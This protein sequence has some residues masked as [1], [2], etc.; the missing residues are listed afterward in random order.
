CWG[1]GGDGAVGNNSLLGSRIPVAVQ[2]P[3]GVTFVAI[4]AQ[5]NHSCGITSGGQAYCWGLNGS[6]QLGDGTSTN[7]LVP[8]A[9]SQ[10]VGVT[11]AA[12]SAGS[13][14]TCALDGSGQG[15]CWGLNTN[16]Q[17]GNGT[18]TQSLT[19]VAVSMPVGVAF[20]QIRTGS[21]FSCGLDGSVGQAYCWGIN[22][23]S[24]LGDNSTVAKNVPTAVA[25]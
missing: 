1:Y 11:F 23:F 8:T 24:Q 10:P 5:V 18:N 3:M 6:G 20:S 4:D 19:P 14:Q 17:L 22:G 21:S 9:V 7:R 13:N 15:Y 16:G 25:H 12:I 2:Q